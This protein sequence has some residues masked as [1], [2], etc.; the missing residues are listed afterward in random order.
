MRASVAALH[1]LLA[2]T[3]SWG[4]PTG[5]RFTGGQGERQKSEGIRSP[6]TPKIPIR[7]DRLSHSMFIT[8]IISRLE[9][10]GIESRTHSL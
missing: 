8:T 2:T 7:A 9:P 5:D 6:F 1:L 3:P 4:S 10:T